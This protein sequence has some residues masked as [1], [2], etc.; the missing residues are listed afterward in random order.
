MNKILPIVETYSLPS[1]E[2]VISY[3]KAHEIKNIDLYLIQGV[4]GKGNL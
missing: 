4:T 3:L 2:G 1:C